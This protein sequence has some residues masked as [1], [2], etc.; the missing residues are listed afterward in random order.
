MEQ[1]LYNTQR[2]NEHKDLLVH[3]LIIF[4]AVVLALVIIVIIIFTQVDDFLCALALMAAEPAQATGPMVPDLIPGHS[5]YTELG[6][7]CICR[8]IILSES[9]TSPI[10]IAISS[11]AHACLSSAS[12]DCLCARALCSMAT[13]RCCWVLATGGQLQPFVI[14]ASTPDAPSLT[15]LHCTFATKHG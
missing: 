6:Q 8:T 7:G 13:A 9:L 12:A 3:L 4:T 14:K 5:G 1:C 15:K 2:T 11:M 10:D